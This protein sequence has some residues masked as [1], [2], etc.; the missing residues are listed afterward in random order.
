MFEEHEPNLGLY[1]QH[2]PPLNK[3]VMVH[4]QHRLYKD[5][6]RLSILIV[7][8]L[9]NRTPGYTCVSLP[10]DVLWEET[11]DFEEDSLLAVSV[12]SSIG[13]FSCPCITDC[14]LLIVY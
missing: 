11:V 12:A 14:N 10:F 8:R 4:L 5:I 6:D 3:E 7:L 13:C 9:V 2:H 1:P